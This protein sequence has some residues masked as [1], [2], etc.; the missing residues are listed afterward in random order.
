MCIFKFPLPKI[1]LDGIEKRPLE[2]IRW[3]ENCS[4]VAF[5][6]NSPVRKLG[7]MS[8][9]MFRTCCLSL[10]L[11]MMSSA[12]VFAQEK[13][14]NWAEKMFSELKYDFGSVARGADVRH[15][16]IITNIYKEDIEI[17]N[18]GTTC[19]C[20]AATPD[21]KLLKTHEKARINVEMNTKKF[22]RQ[23]D[24]NVDV[25]VRFNGVH[26][27]TI[28]V[29]ISAYIRPDVVVTPGNAEFGSVEFG[30]GSERTID[31]SYAG[32]DDW[33]IKDVRIGNDHIKAELKQM[34]RGG[35]Q[36]SY[37]L[38]VRLDNSA[39]MGTINDQIVLVTDDA[40]SLE[41]PIRI[42]GRVEPDIVIA[43]ASF[44]LGKL[45]P[46]EQKTFNVVVR[47]K[48]NFTIAG[49]QCDDNPDCF[50]VMQLSKEAK[51]V[52]VL[53]LRVTAPMT[54]G[55]FKEN[56]TLTIDGRPTPL[57]FTAEGLIAAN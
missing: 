5:P 16:I 32:R 39:P 10:T 41:V 19:G 45:T 51:S 57:T 46:G 27:K 7:V 2:F 42:S 1:G 31:I 49:I 11:L 25:T 53:P 30:N 22:M 26:T 38:V 21:K 15:D 33:T 52:H 28:R 37:Q 8:Q 48:H 23:K 56:F 50:E 40:K 3:Q 36:V 34:A 14:L 17:V 43:P 20:T 47:G 12:S 55:D 54:P 13:E 18:V 9:S 44:P 29:P 4:I 35:G 6:V 24:S